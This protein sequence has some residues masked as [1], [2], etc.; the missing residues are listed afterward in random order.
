MPRFRQALILAYIFLL[1]DTVLGLTR[2]PQ[3]ASVMSSTRRTEMPARYIARKKV[4]GILGKVANKSGGTSLL[5]K[6][7]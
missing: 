1:I 2:V 6:N 7:I 3:S 5:P 4:S